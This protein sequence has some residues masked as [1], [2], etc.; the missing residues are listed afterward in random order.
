M[1]YAIANQDNT[2][3]NRI[4]RLSGYQRFCKKNIF[5]LQMMTTAVK[6]SAPASQNES[7]VPV[8][9]SELFSSANGKRDIS[10][11]SNSPWINQLQN[12]VLCTHRAHY[13]SATTVGE[14][15]P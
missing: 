2:D 10:T 1:Q 7:M 13:C 12:T 11:D 3:K 15:V 9:G 6:H 8:C 4:S 5:K 14:D